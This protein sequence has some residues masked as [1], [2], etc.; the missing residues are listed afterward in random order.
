MADTLIVV[1]KGTMTQ[2]AIEYHLDILLPRP[3]HRAG[4]TS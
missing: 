1:Y 3:A 2:E 4:S